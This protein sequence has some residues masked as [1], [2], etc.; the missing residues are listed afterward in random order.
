LDGEKPPAEGSHVHTLR[1]DCGG[2]FRLLGQMGRCIEAIEDP[3][4]EG[5]R[6]DPL[7]CVGGL[8]FSAEI[9]VVIEIIKTPSRLLKWWPMEDALDWEPDPVGEEE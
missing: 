6:D 8:V 1:D 4:A 2:L 9:D 5:N 7:I 3:S